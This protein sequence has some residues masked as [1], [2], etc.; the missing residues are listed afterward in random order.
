MFTY[1]LPEQN[2]SSYAHTLSD[3]ILSLREYYPADK[4]LMQLADYLEAA[5]QSDPNVTFHKEHKYVTFPRVADG[6]LD[7]LSPQF[8]ILVGIVMAVSVC[9][10]WD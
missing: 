8:V 5:A 1:S 4:F 9:F 3:I 2:K 10:I 7:I 6:T